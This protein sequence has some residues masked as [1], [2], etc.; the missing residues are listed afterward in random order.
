VALEFNQSR[1]DPSLV[2]ARIT[3][4]TPLREVT[5]SPTDPAQASDLP[6]AVE[7]ILSEVVGAARE[8]LGEALRCVVLFGSGADGRLRPSSDVNV[9]F[10]LNAFER[11]SVD[12]LRE[13][14]R[15]A[16]AAVRLAPMFV[17]S[18][19]LPAAADAFAAKFADVRRRRRVLYGD[20]VFA[21]LEVPRAAE[22]A[23]LRQV[24]L[25]LVLRLRAEYALKSL[26]EEQLVPVIAE[27]AGP[28]RACAA[29]LLA[30]ESGLQ[31]GPKEALARVA[32]ALPAADFG[33]ALEHLSQARESRH[34]PAGV[35]A[36]TL[37]ALLDLAQA[38]RARA[39]RLESAAA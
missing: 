19:E 9:M 20:D 13:T 4:R 36:P 21:G 7:R 2:Y 32:A 22:I 15:L 18:D 6:P 33:E 28:L 10:V 12:A 24:L 27:S 1:G 39:A 16:Q 14:L 17:R 35:A 34:L 30:L 8:A 5:V 26:R 29:S 11:A 23:R 38:L 25:N 3:G 31:L 37:F